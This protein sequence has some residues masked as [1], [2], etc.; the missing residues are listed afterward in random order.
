MTSSLNRAVLRPGYTAT[1]QTEQ[2]DPRQEKN[3]AGGFAFTVDSAQRVRRFL[4][5]GVET[6]TFYVEQRKLQTENVTAVT[7]WAKARPAELVAMARDISVAGIAQR[8]DAAIFALTAV[9]ALGDEAGKRAAEAAFPDVVRTGTHLYTAAGFTENAR[10]W[11]PVARRTFASWYL[12]KT[13]DELAYQLVKYRQRN[14]WTHR[15]V[16]RL[17]HSTRNA[18]QAHRDLFN[19]ATHGVT[20][21]DPLPRWIEALELARDIERSG[22]TAAQKTLAYVQLIRDYPGAPWEILPDEATAQADVWRVLIENGMPITALMRN[23]PRLT[24]LGVIAPMSEHLALVTGRLTDAELLRKGRVH[25]LSVLIALATYALGHSLN[26]ESRWGTVPQV[27]DALNDAFYLAFGTVHPADKRIMGSLD[28]SGSMAEPIW[29]PQVRLDQPREL[30]YPFTAAQ[31]T[32]AM[33]MVQMATE[34]RYGAFAFNTGIKPVDISPRMRLDDVMRRVAGLT[35]GGT[36]CSLP[37][38]WAA[39]NRVEVDVFQ[40]YTDNETWAGTIHPHEALERYRQQ[41]GINA[42]LQVIAVAPTEFSIADPS[43]GG[44]L[45]VAGFGSDVPG[46]LAAH[47]RGDV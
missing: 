11:G 20:E 16:L 41:M 35:Y 14:G 25:P 40:V 22:E 45:D 3:H 31:I 37:M 32:A 38:V 9:L 43:D 26:G 2:A 13:P 39:R 42:R 34:P 21:R 1:P 19:W 28:V 23:L 44:M 7:K 24:R 33:S 4:T 29:K 27:A 36:D 47:G 5:L 30:Q 6:G 17:A 10:G 18:D 12:A 8:N 46:L 15:D